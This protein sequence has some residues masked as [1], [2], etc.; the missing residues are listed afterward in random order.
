MEP[1]PAWQLH[2]GR[3]AFSGP[4]VDHLDPIVPMVIFDPKTGRI[5]PIPAPTR[6]RPHSVNTMSMARSA[7]TTTIMVLEEFRKLDPELPI[8]IALVLMLVARKPN[9]SLKELTQLIGQGEASVSCHLAALSKEYGGKGLI[10]YFEAP[11]D[12]CNKLA[13]LTPDGERFVRSITHYIE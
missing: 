1:T 4:L 2:A 13:R 11:D 9:I 7:L 10:T 6:P 8:Q 12:R 5:V 3:G